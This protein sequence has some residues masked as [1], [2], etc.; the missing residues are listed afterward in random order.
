MSILW[1]LLKIYG[2]FWLEYCF[3]SE[4][5]TGMIVRPIKEHNMILQAVWKELPPDLD[6]RQ[7]S[8]VACNRS[9]E[10]HSV[11]LTKTESPQI[12]GFLS[13]YYI[14]SCIKRDTI[15]LVFFCVTASVFI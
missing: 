1:Y 4:D 5:L 13:S 10:V 9:S 11:K 6:E 8:L 14:P 12:T 3:A 2:F 15:A 7:T